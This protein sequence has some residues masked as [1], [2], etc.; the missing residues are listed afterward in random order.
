MS[1]EEWIEELRY[2]DLCS[3]QDRADAIELL[4]FLEELKERRE[5]GEDGGE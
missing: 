3:I 5:R 4:E 2:G 1:L